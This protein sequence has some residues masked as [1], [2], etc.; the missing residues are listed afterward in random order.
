MPVPCIIVT[1]ITGSLAAS[2]SNSPLQ[3][4]FD[5]HTK[6]ITDQRAQIDRN[7]SITGS[8][9][10]TITGSLDASITGSLAASTIIKL[11]AT[12]CYKRA[13]AI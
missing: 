7:A 8:L 11:N 9:V 12:W 3:S 1:T 5:F 6:D 10:A 13:G 4:D 2:V